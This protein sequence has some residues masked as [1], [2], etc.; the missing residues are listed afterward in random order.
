MQQAFIDCDAF[1]CGFCTPGQIISG[2]RAASPRGTPARPAEIREWMS[3]NLCRCGAYPNIVDGGRSAPREGEQAMSPFHY[4][5][6]RRPPPRRSPPERRP[7]AA[8]LAGGTTLLDL[9][10]LEVLEPRP[11][12]STSTPCR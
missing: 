12:W 6:G 4:H 9:M 7:G 11:R 3:G 1:Q 8:F 10:K 2:G 5:A